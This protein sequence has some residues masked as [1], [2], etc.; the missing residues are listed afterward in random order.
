MARAVR[1]K[2][3]LSV[4]IMEARISRAMVAICGSASAITGSTASPMPWLLQP[5][6]G[7]QPSAMAKSRINSGATT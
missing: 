7:S 4:S 2:L 5:P 1:M 3:A 6:A